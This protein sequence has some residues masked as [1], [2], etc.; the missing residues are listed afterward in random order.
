MA[1]KILSIED[2][3][4]LVKGKKIK[5]DEPK[6]F[7]WL[8]SRL[9]DYDKPIDK[10]EVIMNIQGNTILTK[11][12]YCTISGKPKAGKSAFIAGILS[13]AITKNNSL[14][15]NTNLCTKKPNIV[16]L[17]TE[18]GE[19]EYYQSIEM[20][21]KISGLN[22]LPKTL[23]SYRLRGIKAEQIRD[24]IIHIAND[25][26][27][28]LL[29]IDGLLDTIIDFNDLHECR[30]IT[31]ILRDVTEKQKIGIVCIIHQ[32]KSTNYTIG[33]LGSYA[34]RF[35]QSVIEVVKQEKEPVSTLQPVLLRSAGTF[36]NIN[37]Q[38][39]V[40]S[41][42]WKLHE[43]TPDTHKS[44]GLDI[45]EAEI[46]EFS[47]KLFNNRPY[48]IYKQIQDDAKSI[49][50]MSTNKISTLVKQMVE[51]GIIKK[52]GNNYFLTQPPF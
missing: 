49:L 46:W 4:Q 29:I 9:C 10:P 6:N 28:G 32:S 8:K 17:D 37:I 15:I 24:A 33:H 7:D 36:Q 42:I 21:K 16:H 48:V 52:E 18:Q 1:K 30:M 22:K 47:K 11:G 51:M 19:Y 40:N 43:S 39:D 25:P 26:L 3:K 38:F 2:A 27:T 41:K 35:S 50:F 34:D 12:N 44:K 13:G 45:T 31:D 5:Q 23:N 20:V 14:G